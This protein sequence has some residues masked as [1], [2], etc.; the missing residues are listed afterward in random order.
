V[1]IREYS[2]P[3]TVF[4][5]G[6]L[7]FSL[8]CI[9]SAAALVNPSA[10]RASDIGAQDIVDSAFSNPINTAVALTAVEISEYI[11]TPTPTLTLHPTIT[12]SVTAT[13]RIFVTWTPL[14]PT[15][16][17]EGRPSATSTRV[18]SRT[19]T[20][21]LLPSPTNTPNPPTDTPEPPTDTPVPP[22]DT[23]EPPT[24]TPV[25][26]TDTPEP[27]PTDTTPVESPIPQGIPLP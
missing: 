7:G 13:K 6:V 22:T 19:P 16:T 17:R 27:P 2:G 14:P 5:A 21:I 11:T 26:P 12:A 18:P 9:V 8:I 1:K 25:P 10:P 15:R 24:D 20:R 3:L 4:A 23:P